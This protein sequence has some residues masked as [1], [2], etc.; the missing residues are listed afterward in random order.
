M[1][2]PGGRQVMCLPLKQDGG[3]VGVTGVQAASITVN[4]A[5]NWIFILYLSASMASICALLNGRFCNSH[6]RYTANNQDA[7][8]FCLRR[9]L[10]KG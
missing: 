8:L 7:G 2:L 5:N 1:I 6:F 10:Y 4:I 9:K 3:G